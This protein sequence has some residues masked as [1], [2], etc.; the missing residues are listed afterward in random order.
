MTGR[1]S[2]WELASQA[3][4]LDL[5]HPYRV[6]MPQS[7]NHPPFRMVIERRHGD[8]VRADGGSAANELII[9]GGHVGT[10][11]DALA[12]VSQ[13]GVVFGGVPANSILN[14][15]GFARLGVDE[16]P[17]FVGRGVLLD[18]TA[19]HGVD[20]LEPGYEVT[21]DDL[22]A[23]QERADAE[24]RPGDVVLIGTGWSRRWD[25]R[26]AFV[27]LTDGVPGPGLAAGEWLAQHRPRMVGG[28]AITFE[29]IAPGLGHALLPVHRTMLVQNGIHII[30]TMNLAPLIEA[31]AAEFLLILAGLNLVGAT[32][33]P[34]RPLALVPP[35]D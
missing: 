18:V 3:R 35:T 31:Q 7:P 23:A 11:I 20:V 1:E 10:H 17:P 16:F 14:H 32:G 25:E 21:P 9:L 33:S 22:I 5:A 24:L 8:M 12:H 4:P 13:D 15:Q 29:R 2:L 28:E 19:V 34:V 30:E 27:G 6:G 26:E